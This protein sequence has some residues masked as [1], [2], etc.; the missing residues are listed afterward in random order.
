MSR[1]AQLFLGAVFVVA[2]VL[3]LADLQ[4]FSETIA[5]YRLLPAAWSP[6]LATSLVGTELLLGV[7]MLAGR[8]RRA[9]A[10][11]A[12][13]LIGAF[14]VAMASALVRGID[15][16]CG[17]FGAASS[18]L[19]WGTFLRDALLLVPATIAARSADARE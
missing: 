8:M 15:V 5:N 10:L 4:A 19:S 3:K 13:V 12:L 18:R 2:A 14:V 6:P 7:T 16:S 9:C 11:V 17:C 1:A